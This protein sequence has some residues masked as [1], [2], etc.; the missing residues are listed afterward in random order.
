MMSKIVCEPH[1]PHM[2]QTEPT[3][4]KQKEDLAKSTGVVL[5]KYPPKIK[6]KN[7][8]NSRV[9]ELGWI[10]CTLICEGFGVFIVV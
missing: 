6:L 3:K 8:H 1:D 10:M 5:A 2:L 9:L 4:Q 7:L